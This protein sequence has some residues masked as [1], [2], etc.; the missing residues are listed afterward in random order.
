MIQDKVSILRQYVFVEVVFVLSLT[1]VLLAEP[2]LQE[3]Q[4]PLL[5]GDWIGVLNVLEKTELRDTDSSC[6]MV[7]AHAYLATNR[8]NEA[9]ILFLAMDKEDLNLWKDWT[10]LLKEQHPEIAYVHYFYGDAL[11]RV[12]D[13]DEG[14]NAFNQAIDLRPKE[15]LFWTARGVAKAIHNDLDDALLDINYAIGLR[16]DYADAHASIGTLW[17]LQNASPGAIEAFNRAINSSCCG[18]V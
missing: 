1:R 11:M 15:S 7:A 6:R 5:K 9:L 16:R 14:L 12:G 13:Y 18:K 4:Q 2:L 8:N 3:L 10:S 17:V